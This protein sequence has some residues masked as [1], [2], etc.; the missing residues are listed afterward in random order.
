MG[1]RI[2]TNIAA[3]GAQ[4]NLRQVIGR[5]EGN[6]RRLSSGLRTA[7][8]A[9]D[10]AGLAISEKLGSDIRAYNQAS[11]NAND[12]VSLA[13]TADGA[14]AE[15][16]DILKRLK[17]IVLQR[18][19]GTTDNAS[20]DTL[21]TEGQDLINEIDRIATTTKFNGIS[22]LDGTNSLV[23]FQVGIG[24]TSNDVISVSLSDVDKTALA[25]NSLVLNSTATNTAGGNLDTAL[26]NVESAL[27]TVNTARGRFGAALARLNSTVNNLGSIS[28]NLS[29]AQSRI[30]D[31]D[32]ASESSDLTRNSII[33]QS[34][35]AILAQAN[36]RPQAALSLLQ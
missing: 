26:S 18:K 36:V 31:V 15:L 9:D 8:A 17:E 12:G 14:I 2:N 20:A 24:S 19:N 16:G 1:L 22:L 34:A 5:L 10:A 32:V 27:A 29:A 30:R 25:I 21:S 6:F 7:S 23:T 35:I 28:L 3:L 33:Q 11:R 4:N 13:Q